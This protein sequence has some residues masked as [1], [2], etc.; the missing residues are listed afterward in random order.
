MAGH[1]RF[2]GVPAFAE[3]WLL[4]DAAPQRWRLVPT[5]DALFPQARVVDHLTRDLRTGAW[6]VREQHVMRPDAVLV[7]VPAGSSPAVIAARLRAAGFAAGDGRPG[8]AVVV[9]AL[10]GANV[11][12]VF[13]ALTQL[14]ALAPDLVAE[15]DF[16]RFPTQATPDDYQPAIAWGLENIEAPAAWTVSTGGGD[17]VVVAV[18]D[19]GMHALHSD[20]APNLWTNPGE[21]AGNGL[22]DD[23]NGFVD[24]VHGW[25]FSANNAATIDNDGHGTHVC[26]TIGAVGNNGQGVTGVNWQIRLLPLRV[27]DGTFPDSALI[28]ALRYLVTLRNRGINLVAINASLGGGGFNSLFRQEISSAGAAGMVLVAAAGNDGTNNDVSPVYPASYDVDSIIAVAAIHQGNGRSTFSN[29]G[30]NTVDLAAPGTGIYSTVRTGTYGYLSGTSMAAPHVTGAVAL[31]AAVEPT[32]S[33]AQRR[34]R[35]LD[36]AEPVPALAG[37]VGTGGK[38]NLRR[39][40]APTT[41]RPHVAITTPAARVVAMDRMGLSLT[42]AATVLPDHGS[43]ANATLAWDAPE[44]AADVTFSATSGATTIA[45]FGASGRYRIRVRATAGALVESDSLVIAVTAAAP[46]GTGLRARWSFDEAGGA[47]LDSSGDNRTGILSG[48][49]RAPGVL[50]SA[51]SLNGTTT[52][53]GFTAPPLSRVTIAGWARATGAGN[54]IFPRV[55]HMQPGLLFFGLDNGSS[56]DDGNNGTLKFALDDGSA[57]PVWHTAPGTIALNTWYHVAA[58]YDPG[59][60]APAPRFY[61]NGVPQLLGVQPAGGAAV[62]TVPAGQGFLGD[63]GDATRAWLGQLDEIRVYDRE[64]AASELALLGHEVT[65]HAVLDGAITRGTA[66]DFLE[67]PLAFTL[68]P[69]GL[70]AP[71]FVETGWSVI[72]G[73]ASFAPASGIET[74][75]TVQDAGDFVVRFDGTTTAG[76]HVVRTLPVTVVGEPVTIPGYY[77]GTTSDDGVFVLVVNADGGGTFLGSSQGS[78]HANGF[79]VAEWGGFA[80]TDQT[81]AGVTGRIDDGGG[82]TGSLSGGGTFAGARLNSGLGVDDPAHDGSYG[83]WVLDS[84]IRAVAAVTRGRIALVVDES[85][86]HRMAE[87]PIDPA[88]DFALAPAGD[89]TFSGSVGEGRL[90]ADIAL[91]GQPARTIVLLRE[92]FSP[93]RRLANLSLRGAVGDGAAALIPGFVVQSGSEPLP[94]LVRGIGPGLEEFEIANFIPQPRLQL[95]NT[96]TLV[97]ENAGWSDAANAVAISEAATRLNAFPLDPALGDAAVLTTLMTGNYTAIISGQDGTGGI[98]LA[99][100]YDARLGA[101]NA[102]LVNL[103]GRGFV[104]TGSAILIGGFVIAGDAPALVL[105][106]GIGPT[107]TSFNVPGALSQPVL[108]IF[109]GPAAFASGMAWGAGAS[110]SEV[111]IAANLTSAFPLPANSADAA[112]LLYLEPGN[113]T[114]QVTGVDDAT[115]IALVEVYLVADF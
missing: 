19:S 44:G 67:V 34:A 75:M 37:I 71:V 45:T 28:N 63:R 7:G 112:L 3:R 99:E 9:V 29:F 80:F 20:L 55:V 85:G 49:T 13:N 10:P 22:D 73:A 23:N 6:Q 64:L 110:A 48:A 70:P 17:T 95:F 52:N 93:E 26:G 69:T 83:G 40:V 94:M 96:G 32:L 31:L 105:V 42:L 8:D 2:A 98:A 111:A 65:L 27:G 82:V 62:P 72:A 24:D 15:P 36:T 14:Q 50:G 61:I 84:G 108:T 100:V 109:R 56:D 60:A 58:T 5:R 81:G 66:D 89:A 101:E 33:V 38:L 11:D 106:R 1:D 57:T 12:S 76:V 104:G 18:L 86:A 16:L 51:V 87:G 21:I 41:L 77:T 115:G 88:G 78:R 59:A 4:D 91:P 74:V 79:T 47:A 43:T 103:S 54:S 35:I 68:A 25:D 97:A 39:V 107:L 114:A 53:V 92:G 46:E 113:Y 90:R 30:V 102:R